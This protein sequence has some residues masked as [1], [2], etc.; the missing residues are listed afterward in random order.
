MEEK[1]EEKEMPEEPETEAT[2]RLQKPVSHLSFAL[3]YASGWDSGLSELE[4][5]P[6]PA[7]SDWRQAGASRPFSLPPR[8]PYSG[9]PNSLVPK[10][11]EPFT[12][13]RPRAPRGPI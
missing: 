10:L 3:N 8:S 5:V 2:A 9:T 6:P 1:Q 7:C 13:C 11:R 4:R 12:K